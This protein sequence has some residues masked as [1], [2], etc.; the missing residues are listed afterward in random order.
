MRRRAGRQSIPLKTTRGRA[1]RQSG[2]EADGDKCLTECRHRVHVH[3]GRLDAAT[4]V[5]FG[6]AVRTEVEAAAVLPLHLRPAAAPD[7]EHTHTVPRM[8]NG[9]RACAVPR[10]A[11]HGV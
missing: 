1:K 5:A 11:R 7:S 8:M 9:T 6:E 10:Q 2:R 3:F 4:T